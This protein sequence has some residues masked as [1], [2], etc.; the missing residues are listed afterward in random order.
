MRL[1]LTSLAVSL[2]LAAGLAAAPASS[3]GKRAPGATAAAV[4]CKSGYIRK[5]VTVRGK[6]VKRCVKDTRTCLASFKCGFLRTPD[7][8]IE[9]QF[10]S[11]PI[12]AISFPREIMYPIPGC[13]PVPTD[14]IGAAT[15]GNMENT[16][17][18]FR[19]RGTHVGATLFQTAAD[20]AR[21][22]A[23][24]SDGRGVGIQ[25]VVTGRWTTTTSITGAITAIQTRVQRNPDGSVTVTDRCSRTVPIR[26]I[27]VKG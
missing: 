15:L 25:I 7:G 1:T 20:K 12:P 14:P 10:G 26:L 23:S 17:G 21:G 11:G 3:S 4:K 5:T 22:G 8:K 13:G 18:V 6:R 9:A 19:V 27:K 2:A 24:T 16:S